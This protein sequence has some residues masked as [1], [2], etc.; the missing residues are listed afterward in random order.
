MLISIEKNNLTFYAYLILW[1]CILWIFNAMT[2]KNPSKTPLT[3]TPQELIHIQ[4]S[5][6]ARQYKYWFLLT[7]GKK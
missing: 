6:S 3:R 4:H 2:P 7:N 5:I 1:G